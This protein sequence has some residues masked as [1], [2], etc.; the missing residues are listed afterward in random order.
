MQAVLAH[1]KSW[2]PGALDLLDFAGWQTIPDQYADR[3]FHEHN[4]LN[5]KLGL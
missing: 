3:P 5:Q 1:R 2:L 4:R